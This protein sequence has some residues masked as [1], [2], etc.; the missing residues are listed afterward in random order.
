M[1]IIVPTI[2]PSSARDYVWLTGAIGTY[3]GNRT[4]LADKVPD[5]VILAEQ[6]IRADLEARN[7]DSVAT[8]SVTGGEPTA[9]LPEDFIEPRVLV[10]DGQLPL[11]YLTPAKFDA[12]YVSD[13]GGVPRHYTVVGSNLRLGPTPSADASLILTYRAGIPA[14]A[15]SGGSNWLIRKNANV[16]LAACMVEGAIPYTKNWADLQFWEKKYT[17]AIASVNKLDWSSA[18]DMRVRSDVRAV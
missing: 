7:Q 1:S 2:A 17:D 8:L 4:D 14:L 16:Y 9:T 18:A 10:M 15:D 12:M 3:S 6:R 13:S 5:F 11:D